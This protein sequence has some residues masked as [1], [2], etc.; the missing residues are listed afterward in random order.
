MKRLLTTLALAFSAAAGAAPLPAPDY[1]PLDTTARARTPETLVS[2]SVRA[3]SLE[4]AV[5]LLKQGDSGLRPFAAM[6]PSCHKDDTRKSCKTKTLACEKAKSFAKKYSLH[7][8]CSALYDQA[9][10]LLTTVPA[11][12]Q[13]TAGASAVDAGS[14]NSER[15][16][17]Q[18][19]P[20]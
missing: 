19:V 7:A 5:A 3:T 6:G 1:L 11:P 8:V 13:E 14:E 17:S 4:D 18:A 10:I 2:Q 12:T 9:T 15:G 20:Q 16:N